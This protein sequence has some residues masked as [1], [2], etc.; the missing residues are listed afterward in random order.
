MR[1]KSTHIM[2]ENGRRRRGATLV[3][4]A[5]LMTVLFGITALAVDFSR[6]YSFKAEL[7]RLTDAAALSGALDVMN[8]APTINETFIRAGIETLR[9]NNKIEVDSLAEILNADISAVFWDFSKDSAYARNFG[10][11]D[12]NGVRVAARYRT[13]W[14]LAR[15]FGA[16]DR[17]MNDT[18]VAA[19]GYINSS[20][21]VKPWAIP[22]SAMLDLL[23]R[24]PTDL[25]H[26]L[27]SADLQK[28]ASQDS[29]IG[30][31]DPQGNG[32]GDINNPGN[33]GWVDPK[34]NESGNQNE[35]IA[36]AIKGCGADEIGVGD[37]IPTTTGNRNEPKI[38]SA[39]EEL[40]G[41]ASMC[42]QSKPPILVPIFEEVYRQGGQAE[43]I[44]KY[45]G[46]FK[47][48]YQGTQP[49][50]TAGV[51]LSQPLPSIFPRPSTS[52]LRSYF[53]QTSYSPESQGNS[54]NSGNSGDNGN[55]D[56]GGGSQWNVCGY[57]TS[58]SIPPSGGL[59]NILSPIKA[60][61]IVK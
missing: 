46:A 15:F 36:N 61:A 35:E 29:L 60:I 34:P 57:L 25:A 47:L 31:K 2:P 38:K 1:K 58:V 53:V 26:D 30:F 14:S 23:G 7:K 4:V 11:P 50:A 52:A 55:S 56:P 19:F 20:A 12:V 22:Y 5:I 42:D 45:I 6:M 24:D 39:I 51:S 49:C 3:L 17:T 54:G 28:L 13:S 33:F 10:D 9:S 43:Y 8:Q 32:E 16:N 21:C 27:T 44:I 18:S 48:M 37:S 40:C 41:G 59:T